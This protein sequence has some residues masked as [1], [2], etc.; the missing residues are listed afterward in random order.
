[1]SPL[2]LPSG[3][4]AL[5]YERWV[6]LS[7]R[8]TMRNSEARVVPHSPYRQWGGPREAAYREVSAS[9]VLGF[10]A[11]LVLL[12]KALCAEPSP[13]EG[14][15]GFGALHSTGHLSGGHGHRR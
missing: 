7:T 12:I 9:F 6:R 8:L 11:V 14:F 13:T 2:E 15:G 1:M 4:V 3:E 10:V 5:H